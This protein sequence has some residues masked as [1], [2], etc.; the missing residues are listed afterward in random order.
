[1]VIVV[2]AGRIPEVF[3][4]IFREAFSLGPPPAAPPAPG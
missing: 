4:L 2:H 1:M 3:A